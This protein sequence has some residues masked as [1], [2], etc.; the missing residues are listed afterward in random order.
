MP[1]IGKA[2]S[3]HEANIARADHGNAHGETY[4]LAMT[5]RGF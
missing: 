5:R 4:R 2:G 3:G 1:E